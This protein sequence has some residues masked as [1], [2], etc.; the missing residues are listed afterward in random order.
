MCFCC[1]E[2]FIYCAFFFGSFVVDFSLCVLYCYVDRVIVVLVGCLRSVVG[3]RRIAG[4]GM[5]WCGVLSF[6]GFTRE[7]LCWVG[8]FIVDGFFSWLKS[9]GLQ[10]SLGGRCFCCVVFVILYYLLIIAII[11]GLGWGASEVIF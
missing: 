5:V 1:L 3:L 6:A 2:I 7:T 11:S 8:D 4:S 9:S 10:L